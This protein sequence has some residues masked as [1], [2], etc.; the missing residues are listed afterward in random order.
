MMA[1]CLCFFLANKPRVCNLFPQSC[2][3][4][5]QFQNFCP[6]LVANFHSTLCT[7]YNHK[8]SISIHKKKLSERL[9]KN[10][11]IIKE[12]PPMKNSAMQKRLARI[13]Q[14][15]SVHTSPSLLLPDL[16]T[17]MSLTAYSSF[18]FLQKSFM[19]MQSQLEGLSC[20]RYT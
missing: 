16:Q 9:F 13:C 2:T 18:L 17:P 10:E 1:Q 14:S 15:S 4:V 6:D 12:E 7:Q 20:L 8:S 5:V 11:T 19:Y 3:T